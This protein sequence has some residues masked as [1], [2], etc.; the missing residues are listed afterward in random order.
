MDLMFPFVSHVKLK[1]KSDGETVTI[2][3][4]D[5]EEKLK[6]KDFETIS[7]DIFLYGKWENKKYIATIAKQDRRPREGVEYFG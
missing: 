5:L 6:V 2:S 1:R 3:K 4:P 7:G